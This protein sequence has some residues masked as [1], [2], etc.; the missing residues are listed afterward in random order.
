MQEK[1]RNARNIVSSCLT[2]SW[3][4]RAVIRDKVI[5]DSKSR[6]IVL[7]QVELSVEMCLK[8]WVA[9]NWTGKQILINLPHQS[10]AIMM[11]SYNHSHYTTSNWLQADGL[12]SAE[13]ICMRCAMLVNAILINERSSVIDEQKRRRKGKLSNQNFLQEKKKKKIL[14]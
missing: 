4:K 3:V 5:Q 6:I 10:V 1:K 14:W 2:T 11:E 8:G 9:L 12:L 13:N 7:R